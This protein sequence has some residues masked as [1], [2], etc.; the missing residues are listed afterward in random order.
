MSLLLLLDKASYIEFFTEIAFTTDPFDTPVWEPVLPIRVSSS[1]GRQTERDHAETG[2]S[3]SL[4]DNSSRDFD[5]TNT[6]GPYYPNVV[7]ERRIRCRATNGTDTWGIFSHF[8]EGWPQPW[9]T[10]A[11]SESPVGATDGF[12]ILAQAQL[13]AGTSYPEQTTG[14]RIGAILD[15]V[16]WPA[17]DRDIDTGRYLVQAAPAGSL[18]GSDAL[19]L[20]FAV[21]DTE[22]G[23]AFLDGDG[24]FVFHDRYRRIFAPGETSLV[25][26]SDNPA[27]G[28]LLYA[29]LTATYDRRQIVNDFRITHLGGSEQIVEDTASI[30]KFRRRT[31]TASTLHVTG[32]DARS[33]A[34]YQVLRDKDPQLRFEELTIEPLRNQLLWE[35]CLGRRIGDRITV[36]RHPPGGGDPIE[37][38]VYIEAIKHDFM[39]L[40]H[41]TPRTTWRLSPA[42]ERT[43]MVADDAALGLADS[44]N[45]AG[46]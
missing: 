20:I 25:T 27:A 19:S 7:P 29:K 6:S 2:R 13:P 32:G 28:E 9:E 38:D 23:V 43:Y 22:L 37:Q 31:R 40:A 18:D 26:F 12:E 33:T 14:E 44:G 10:P 34:E 39:S 30:E 5:P 11:Y 15:D 24:V 21:S 8:V 46:P 16:G 4:L 45:L 35:Q 36:L 17:A 1:M 41:G 42:D 3:T